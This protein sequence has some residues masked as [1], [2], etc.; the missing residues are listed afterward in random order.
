MT[1][2]KYKFIND[3]LFKMLFVK[4]PH[5]LKN[6]IA[7]LLGIRLESIKQFEIRNP[8]M[9]PESLGDKFCH[10]DINMTVDGQRVNLEIQVERDGDF[11]ARSLYYWA[12][13][14]STALPASEDYSKL[15]RTIIINIIN[16]KEY[17]CDEFYSEFQLLEVNRHTRMS[18]KIGFY[19]FELKK[20][21]ADINAND[22]LLLWLSLF[23]AET[24]EE[25]LKIE[26]LEV[27]EMEQAIEAYRTITVTPEF[28][29]MERLRSKARHD[30]ASALNHARTD[31]RFVIAKNLLKKQMPIDDIADATGLTYSEVEG[32]QN[33][34]V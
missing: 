9:P 26:A 30:E 23:K 32:L 14:Y 12:R 25:L 5:L 18:D 19:F 33:A 1:E 4:Y 13:E 21:P 8:E 11:A 6:L 7:V 16:F 3:V 15:P 22:L 2:L 27:P 20:L 28:K 24:E 31:E 10:L 34:G 17:D 29:E